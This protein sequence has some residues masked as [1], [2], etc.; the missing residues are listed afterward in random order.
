MEFLSFVIR[1]IAKLYSCCDRQLCISV[2]YG[3][4]LPLEKGL[5]DLEVNRQIRI[6]VIA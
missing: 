1:Q 2:L 3:D 4:D 6:G 5:Q